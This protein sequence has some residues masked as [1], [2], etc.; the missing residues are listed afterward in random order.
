M[1][2]N[3]AVNNSLS[4]QT[5]TGNFVGST[6]PTLTTPNLGTPTALVLTNATGDQVGTTTNDNA[7]AGHVGEF[8]SS[9]IAQ[10]SGVALTSTVVR[11]ITSISLTAGDWDVYGN[12]SFLTGSFTQVEGWTNNASATLPDFSLF[13]QITST[14]T[15]QGL[16]V[17]FRR[18]SLASPT[19]IYLSAS[20]TFGGV[21]TA[22]G[23]IYAR[24]AR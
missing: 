14:G 13:T 1:T 7:A 8:V 6:S 16:A 10:A 21:A 17:P 22:F 12:V 15:S 3:N 18:Y 2:T 23:G 9:V 5:G 11:D 4:G 19:T 20:A 24:R